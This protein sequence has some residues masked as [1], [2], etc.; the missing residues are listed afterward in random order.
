MV[1]G[2]S[3]FNPLLKT[4]WIDKNGLR[5]QPSCGGIWKISK[6]VWPVGAEPWLPKSWRREH[7]IPP[8]SAACP[9]IADF[10]GNPIQITSILNN[11]ILARSPGQGSMPSIELAAQGG[12]KNYHWFLNGRPV[13]TIPKGQ[14]TFLTLP[15]PGAYQLAVADEAGNS[16]VIHFEILKGLKN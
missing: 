6:G 11:S 2:T 15:Q 9:D 14:V 7:L 5:S 1:S 16:D 4:F 12:K 8:P 13:K 3:S 10:P